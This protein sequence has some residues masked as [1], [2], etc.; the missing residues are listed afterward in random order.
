MHQTT[1]VAIFAFVDAALLKPL[2]YPNPGTLVDVNESVPLFPRSNLSY[3]DYLDWKRLNR[4]F[5]ALDVYRP[6][7]L[8]LDTVTGAE[9]VSGARVSDGFFQTLGISPFLGRIRQAHSLL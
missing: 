5:A 2:P 3:P 1:R 8:T 6:E 7:P 9:E 4:G